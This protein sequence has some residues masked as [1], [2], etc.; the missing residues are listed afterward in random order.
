MSPKI[1]RRNTMKKLIPLLL[2]LVMIVS[3]FAACGG[4]NPQQTSG[5]KPNQSNPQG[6]GTPT[7]G[8][9]TGDSTGGT[10][11]VETPKDLNIDLD[12]LDYGNRKFFVYHWTTATPEFAVDEDKAEGDPIQEALYQRNLKLEEGLGIKLNFHDEA[13]NDNY[14]SKFVETLKTRIQDPETPVDL[15]AA[16]SRTAPHVM[17]AGLSIDLL[18]YDEDLD[19]TKVWW[20]ALVRETHEIKGRLFYTSGDASTGLLTMIETLFMNKSVFASLGHD[21]EQFMKDVKNGNWT[22]EDLITFCTGVYQDLDDVSG[23]SNGDMFGIIAENVGFGDGMWTAFGY[24]LFDISNEDD[25]VYTLSS[26]LTGE[27]A[28]SFVKLMTDFCNSADAHLQMEKQATTMTAA[29]K[30]AAFSA[31]KTLFMEM[32]MTTFDASS[33]DCDYTILPL[34]KGSD[35]QERY[36]TCVGNPYALF[37][38]CSS[39]VDKDLVAQTLQTWGYYGYTLTTP[40]VFEVTFKGKVAKDDY[41]IQMFDIIRENITFEIGRTFDRFTSTMLPNLVSRA[42]VNNNPWTSVL[43]ATKKVVLNA[44]MDAANAKIFAIL[45]ITE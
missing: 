32:R 18:A 26:D 16:Y 30:L 33:V 43:T 44:S 27:N 35:K 31:G 12:A 2:A 5:D 24:K 1:K 9:G 21:Y 42:W 13:G 38:I 25:V 15:I 28:S 40:A 45:D 41:A 39:A 7:G 6:T 29:E 14:Q 20:P 8:D 19:L 10:T 23:E 36:Y 34:P 37:S 3:V 17:A 22:M 4:N 11:D